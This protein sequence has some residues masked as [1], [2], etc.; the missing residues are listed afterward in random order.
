ML[1]LLLQGC[2]LAV[3]RPLTCLLASAGVS[4]SEA[5]V[6]EPPSQAWSIQGGVWVGCSSSALPSVGNAQRKTCG[7]LALHNMVTQGPRGTKQFSGRTWPFPQVFP[8]LH[9]D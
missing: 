4:A 8:Q 7:S 6:M 5:S 2:E 3:A 1:E 9:P